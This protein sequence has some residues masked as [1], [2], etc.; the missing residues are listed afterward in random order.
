MRIA[1]RQLAWFL[2]LAD[3]LLGGQSPRRLTAG[4]SLLPGNVPETPDVLP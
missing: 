3:P 4:G 1:V 2:V